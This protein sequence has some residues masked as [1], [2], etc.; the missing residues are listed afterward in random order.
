MVL[1]KFA[2]SFI[3]SCSDKKIDDNIVQCKY[4]TKNNTTTLTAIAIVVAVVP[5]VRHHPGAGH[6]RPAGKGLRGHPVP[7]L[8]Q[9]GAVEP[10][11][12]G[13]A[14]HHQEEPGAGVSGAAAGAAPAVVFRA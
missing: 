1:P 10:G 13:V 11:A 12:P 7:Q 5:R 9:E 2:R 14:R 3:L 8:G 6:G 4:I